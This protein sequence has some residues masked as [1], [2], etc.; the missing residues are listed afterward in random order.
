MAS[1]INKDDL[2]QVVTPHWD[3]VTNH[4]EREREREGV[5]A[6]SCQMSH[7]I[8]YVYINDNTT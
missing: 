4:R 6:G 3:K 2:V 5:V 1:S 8:G 7:R